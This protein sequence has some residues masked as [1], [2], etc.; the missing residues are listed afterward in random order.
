MPWDPP[1]RAGPPSSPRST[2]PP[3]PFRSQNPIAAR[4]IDSF[5]RERGWRSS[6]LGR[7]TP[8]E[9]EI[10]VR[11][12]PT[13]APSVHGSRSVLSFL[14][15]FGIGGEG[16]GIDGPEVHQRKGVR[17]VRVQG[18]GTRTTSEAETE[19]TRFAAPCSFSW[20]SRRTCSSV[21]GIL[22][23]RWCPRYGTSS[24]RRCVHRALV[25]ADVGSRR[26][27][28]WLGGIGF[29]SIDA[30]ARPSVVPPFPRVRADSLFVGRIFD[31]V[32]FRWK[33]RAAVVTDTSSAF[34]ESPR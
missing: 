19:G 7:R 13:R 31:R 17:F 3:S 22:D 9:H 4:A 24:W 26:A 6:C 32:G 27:R 14:D 5:G 28:R 18:G 16:W 23:R 30:V 12:V 2:L 21:P 10:R 1:R 25:V 34:W 15:P 33:E 11:L 29:G 8:T 20:I